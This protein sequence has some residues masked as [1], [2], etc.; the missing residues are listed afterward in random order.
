MRESQ[1]RLPDLSTSQDAIQRLTVAPATGRREFRRERRDAD[2]VIV[3]GGLGGT[4]AAITAARAGLRVTLIQDRPVLGGNSS[5]EV[6]LWVL[7]AT[8]HMHNNNRWAREGGVVEEILVE[9]MYRNPIGNPLIFDTILLEKVVAEPTIDLLLNTALTDVAVEDGH[10]TGVSAFCSQNSTR[11]DVAAPLFLDSSGDGA[12]AFAA[13]AA[14]RMGA[15][16]T[17]EFGEAMAPTDEYGALLGHSIYFYSK[18]VGHPVRFVKP[19]FALDDLS[20]I[21]RARSFTTADDGC[22]L[23]W[24]E[25]GGRLDTVHETETI[26]WRLWQVVYAVWDHLKNSGEFP[27]AENLTLEWVGTIPGKRESRRFEGLTMLRQQDIAEQRTHDDAVALGGWSIDLHPADG[28]F[29]EHP[30]CHQVHTRGVYQIPYRCLVSRDVDNL[31]YAGRMMSASH[32]AFGSTRVMGTA[33]HCAQAVA[34]AA[35][36]CL[37]DGLA[38]AD[39]LAPDRMVE[40][41]RELLRTG[42]HIPG[43]A[44]SDPD[45]LVAEATLSASSELRLGAIPGD[46]TMRPLDEELGQLLPLPAGQVPQLTATLDVAAATTL[47][48]ELRV[49]SRPDDHTYD[50]VIGRC[51]VALEPG[52]RQR[53][54]LDLDAQLEQ[55]GYVCLVLQPDPH[56]AIET[57]PRVIT[58]LAPVR[59]GRDQV[60]DDAIG[61]LPLRMY[62]PI[63]RPEGRN[64]ALRLDPPVAVGALEELATGVERPTGRSNAW[65]ADLDDPAPSLTLRWDGPRTVARIELR[66]DTDFDHGMET[67]L[68][69]HPEPVMPQCVTAC[70]VSAGGREVAR[71]VDNHSSVVTLRLDAPVT[72]DELVIS[73]DAAAQPA[74]V[75]VFAVRCYADDRRIVGHRDAVVSATDGGVSSRS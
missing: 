57:S 19:A 60:A 26:K 17:A 11:Y 56:L 2:L 40:L 61:C 59:R 47:H 14:Y 9:N 46:A 28:V 4:C 32:V 8:A 53:I 68:F 30:G 12:L 33:S 58:G 48:A 74:P 69:H 63:R 25:W 24:I 49:G 38:P 21:P 44:L 35:A 39:L 72:T 10:L 75:A 15:E 62:V 43:L 1:R 27:D 31:F 7:G 29:S 64:L 54:K 37:R 6:R 36:L 55:R 67:V 73:F 13:G 45:D 20:E 52:D 50:R 22:R 16:S 70:T 65:I 18:D 34:V 66:F 42:Q 3:G 71:M 51:E 5:S 41:Q 23:W